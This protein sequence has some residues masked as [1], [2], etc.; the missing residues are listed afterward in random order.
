MLGIQNYNA[1][2][3]FKSSKTKMLNDAVIKKMVNDF[4]KKVMDTKCTGDFNKDIQLYLDLTADSHKI[5]QRIIEESQNK[6]ISY[7]CA[8]TQIGKLNILL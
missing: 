6:T 3:N 4:N 5:L 2:V 8:K 7:E 1:P